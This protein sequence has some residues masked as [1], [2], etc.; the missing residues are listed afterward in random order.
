MN[1]RP[2]APSARW[3]LAA[4]AYAGLI[5]YGS[6]YP[7]TGWTTEQVKVFAF[8][9]PHWPDHIP[10]ADFVTN[11]LAYMPLGVLLAHWLGRRSVPVGVILA[12]LLCAVLSFA[13]EF[14]QQFLP[15]RVASLS[16]LLANTA[17]G[18]AGAVMAAFVHGE[19]LPWVF[20]MRRRDQWFKPGRI[21]DL[22]LLAIALWS[23]S[24]L[25]PLV[26]S[27]DVGKIRQGLSP[28]WQTIQHLE[29]FNLIQWATYE[30]YIAGLALLAVTL[31]APG[32]AVFLR[33]FVLVGCV[34]MTKIV[35]VTRQ[36]SLEAA[37]IGRQRSA[38]QELRPRRFA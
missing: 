25:T 21:V 17:G 5:V 29:R 2:S 20:L 22:G 4:L 15:S 28:I 33:F 26:P 7:L 10:R 38:V 8:L 24:Q 27:I 12:T 19:S 6:L 9:V 18:L 23:L 16:D 14:L 32:R 37:R 3:G 35:I 13:M 11:V 34:L 1:G 30:F 36:L 31:A